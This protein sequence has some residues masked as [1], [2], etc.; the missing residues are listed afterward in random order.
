MPKK[1]IELTNR[2]K[3]QSLS[4]NGLFHIGSKGTL[5]WNTDNET[6]HFVEFEIFSNGIRLNNQFIVFACTPCVA[7]DYRTWMV[8]SDCNRR[9]AIIYEVDGF[10]ACQ[11]CHN[12]NY[13]SQHRWT[14]YR[15]LGNAQAIRVKLGGLPD[16]TKPFPPPSKDMSMK[17]YNKLVAKAMKAESEFYRLAGLGD[18]G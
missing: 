12:L 13:A 1:T 4:R 5:S 3:L 9:I 7:G 10:F 14:P 16:I 15:I 2:L 11:H 6:I 8:C 17:K 18:R